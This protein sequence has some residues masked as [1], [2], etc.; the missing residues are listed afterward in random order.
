LILLFQDWQPV[1]PRQFGLLA[2]AGALLACG[3]VQLVR[4]LR[5]GE[6]S[7]VSPFRY[8]GLLYAM[9]LGFLVWGDAPNALAACGVVLLVGAGVFMLTHDRTRL[10]SP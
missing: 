5:V 1:T 2:G 10:A 3:F 4:A 7:V 9:L 8:T 6:M